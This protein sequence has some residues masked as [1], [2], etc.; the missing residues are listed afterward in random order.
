MNQ[1]RK[2]AA[3]RAPGIDAV[4]LADEQHRQLEQRGDVHR[5][6]ADAF[7][8]RAVAEERH[9]DRAIAALLAGIAG[10]DRERD[11]AADDRGGRNEPERRIAQMQRAAASAVEPPA[12][13]KISASA[14]RRIGAARDHMAVVAMRGRDAGRCACRTDMTAA[15]VASWPI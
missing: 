9:R 10:A 12:R 13:P 1:T 4:V 15:P 6:V 7:L 2:A 11:A 3:R 5:L 8:E 14:A